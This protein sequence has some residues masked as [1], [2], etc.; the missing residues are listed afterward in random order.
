MAGL[1]SRVGGEIIEYTQMLGEARR[2]AVDR[3]VQN[4]TVLFPGSK[5]SA[6]AGPDDEGWFEVEA[7][8]PTRTCLR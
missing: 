6:E 7:V 4:A 3:L 2:L 8:C 5:G 1:R